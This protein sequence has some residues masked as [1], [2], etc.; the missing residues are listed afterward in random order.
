M[1]TNE[2]RLPYLS[3]TLWL[4]AATSLP[5]LTVRSAEAADSYD[6]RAY[7]SQPMGYSVWKRSPA[8]VDSFAQ[9]VED[10]H[11]NATKEQY[12][13]SLHDA[14]WIPQ[15]EPATAVAFIRTLKEYELNETGTYRMGRI[16]RSYRTGE[17]KLDSGFF[18]LI[19]AGERGYFDGRDQLVI[20]I[21]CLNVVYPDRHVA[22]LPAEEERPA[23]AAAPVAPPPPPAA[24][25]PPTDM[26]FSPP[27]PPFPPPPR[28]VVEPVSR[29][30][31]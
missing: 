19:K 8:S 27:P 23:V 20:R 18:Q 17:G 22:V 16:L 14:G 13:Q 21:L 26:H 1:A 31:P 30:V 15:A 10:N 25:K 6:R 12:A 7:Y 4:I 2:F 11:L 28:E 9:L 5:W 3:V 29:S 24:E